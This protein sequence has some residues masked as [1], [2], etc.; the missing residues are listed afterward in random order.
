[1]DEVPLHKKIRKYDLST[2]RIT[3]VHV[4]NCCMTYLQ[5]GRSEEVP[6]LWAYSW[7]YHDFQGHYYKMLG[8]SQDKRY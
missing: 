2:F 8:V 5:S 6:D 7:L 3:T 1:M 4:L